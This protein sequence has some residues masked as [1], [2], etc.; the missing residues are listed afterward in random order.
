[1]NEKKN[2]DVKK[3][4]EEKK[5]IKGLKERSINKTIVNK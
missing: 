1:M 5:A 4:K 2:I 3:L